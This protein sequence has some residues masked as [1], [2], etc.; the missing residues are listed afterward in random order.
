MWQR[1]QGLVFIALGVFSLGDAWRIASTVRDSSTF[2]VLGPDRYLMILGALMILCGI[3]LVVT[4]SL[5][6]AAGPSAEPWWPLPDH[7]AMLIVLAAFVALLPVA[8]FDASCF[9]FFT[10]ALA[11]I[12]KWSWPKAAL[13]A[14]IGVAA[15]HLVFVTFAD[16]PLPHPVWLE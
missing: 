2:D 7:V 14:A 15:L 3:A 8:G 12:S 10:I 11:W 9:V 4:R 13:A 16:V 6:V 1:I 5:A